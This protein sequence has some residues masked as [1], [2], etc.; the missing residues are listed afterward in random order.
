MHENKSH[1]KTQFLHFDS[2][3]ARYLTDFTN[4]SGQPNAYNAQYSM[5]TLFRNVETIYLTSL[6]LPVGFSNVRKG[7]TDTFTFKSNGNI[8]N[9]VLVGKNYS[10]MASLIGDLNIA[11]LGVCPNLVIT[12]SLIANEPRLLI[13]L[14]GTQTISSFSVIDTNLS[15]YILGFRQNYDV[16]VSNTYETTYSS[17]NLNA[18]NY[19]HLFL[20][21]PGINASMASNVKSSFKVPFNSITNQVYFYQD[22]NSFV[23]FIDCNNSNFNLSNLTV[24][25]YDR[26][27]NPL[28]S[29]GLDYSFSL[30]IEYRD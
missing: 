10:T 3:F 1:L 20:N 2:C 8:Y 29:K 6:E 22:Q 14:T 18:D 15:L 23:Q 30:K 25:L 19:F 26:Y 24:I 11:C 28:S 4:P 7:S 12:F 13:T 27:G 9:V 21:V 16:L 5:H 17:F